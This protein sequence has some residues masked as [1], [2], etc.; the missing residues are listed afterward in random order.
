MI[1]LDKGRISWSKE[2]K[3]SGP[4]GQDLLREP[5]TPTMDSEY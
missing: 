4:G 1:C 3:A 2:I 5:R